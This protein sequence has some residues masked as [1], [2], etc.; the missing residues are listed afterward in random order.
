MEPDLIDIYARHLSMG[1]LTD[2][3]GVITLPEGYIQHFGEL[4]IMSYN[5]V[6]LDPVVG[7]NGASATP[8]I[9]REK[10]YSGV[11][12]ISIQA[13]AGA[14]A[15]VIQVAHD[16]NPNK[17]EAAQSPTWVTLQDDAAV[18]IAGPAASKART[19]TRIMAPAFRLKPPT[20][21]GGN[22]T[23]RISTGYWTF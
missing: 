14:E 1:L 8:A 7:V 21:F 19:Y 9:V 18:D 11:D 4:W 16:Y 23:Y 5:Y 2:G 13:P 15:T 10:Q 20:T 6:D 22:R 12:I 3:R 17:D